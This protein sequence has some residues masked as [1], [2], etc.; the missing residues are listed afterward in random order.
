MPFAEVENRTAFSFVGGKPKNLS[1][2]K[3]TRANQTRVPSSCQQ[4]IKKNRESRKSCKCTTDV[5][6]TLGQYWREV[7]DDA[8]SSIPA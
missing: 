3:R 6:W 2:V 8:V 1:G 7:R 4:K 5:K